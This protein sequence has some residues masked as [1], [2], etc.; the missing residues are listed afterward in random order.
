MAGTENG[1]KAWLDGRIVID[2][3]PSVAA[4]MVEMFNGPVP[5]APKP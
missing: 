5:K 1:V 3:D 4:C 2:G